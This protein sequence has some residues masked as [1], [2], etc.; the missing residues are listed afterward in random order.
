[1]K[2]STALVAGLPRR[3]LTALIQTGCISKAEQRV[4]TALRAG[5]HTGETAKQRV[6]EA[7]QKQFMARDEM[8]AMKRAMNHEETEMGLP[9]GYIYKGRYVHR[10]T[11]VYV[12]KQGAVPVLTTTK[13]PEP[14]AAAVADLLEERVAKSRDTQKMLSDTIANYQR[15]HG[16]SR[17]TAIDKVLLGSG[18][19]E[20]VELERKIDE[21]SKLGGGT[22]PTPRPGRM[23]R[24]HNDAAPVRGR[25]GYDSSADGR[26]P[27]NPDAGEEVSVAD[28][29]QLLE[30]IRSG[31]IAFSDPR[32]SALVRLE[33]KMKFEV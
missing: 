22:L 17:E 24:T 1:M 18:V 32:V 8:R 13:D 15:V 10:R 4:I 19:R 21:L 12:R 9:M 31:K 2:L 5:D 20:M 23:H 26:P 6:F 7:V 16:C 33:R 25:T 3:E 28:H 30:D 29:N 11:P 27:H 14:M